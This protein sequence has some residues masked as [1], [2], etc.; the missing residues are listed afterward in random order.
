MSKLPKLE[1]FKGDQSQN[2][3]IW[4]KQFEAHC[5]AA[6]IAEGKKLD[7]LLCCVEGTAFTY[8]CDL[9][10]D[11]ENPATYA[12]VKAAFQQRFCGVEFKRNLEIKLQ[13]LRFRKDTCVSSFIDELY[14]TIKQ[15][16]DIKDSQT[17]TSIAMSHV[18]NNLEPTLREEAKIFQLSGNSKLEN[19][20]EVISIKLNSNSFGQN[21]VGASAMS[22]G[23]RNRLEKL[24]NLMEKVWT[25]LNGGGTSSGSSKTICEECQKPGHSRQNC[26]KL[27][28]CYRCQEVG[29]IGRFC[30]KTTESNASN[31]LDDA[32]VPEQR[33]M[34]QVKLGAQMINC[35]YDTGSQYSMLTRETYNALE[36]KPPLSDV[37]RLGSGIDGRQ[38][39][40]DGI[41]YINLTFETESG[42]PFILEYKP[43]LVSSS[44]KCNIFGA[45]TENRFKSCIR[46]ISKGT[47]TY[48][49]GMCEE[50]ITIH[51]FKEKQSTTNAK[52]LKS[53]RYQEMRFR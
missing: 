21:D 29:H 18:V 2:F 36:T 30:K 52:S 5:A 35:L 42:R 6:T 9:K 28:T 14:T 44:I 47:I 48:R 26:F 15:L 31:N 45:K 50:P 3:A 39:K 27:K 7:T 49:T 8:L 11:E 51:C 22:L 4:I 32:T 19:L 10:E 20:L 23:E 16:Y 25:K 38:F 41:V 33:T 12:N 53:P 46:D 17:V 37:N 43:V 34:I 1:K 24:E 40:F 13:S